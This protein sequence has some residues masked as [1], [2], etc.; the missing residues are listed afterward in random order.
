MW[1]VVTAEGS[2]LTERAGLSEL[3]KTAMLPAFLVKSQVV[4]EVSS[5]ALLAARMEPVGPSPAGASRHLSRPAPPW[6]FSLP[7]EP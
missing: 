6:A 1:G 5:S 3:T 2:P 7:S 4:G